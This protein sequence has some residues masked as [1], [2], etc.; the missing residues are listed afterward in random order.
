MLQL[1]L[2]K[3]ILFVT[4]VIFLGTI[5]IIVNV[6]ENWIDDKSLNSWWGCLHFTS[7]KYLLGK[8]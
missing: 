5:S 4:F 1:C 2:F 3:E 7:H 6:I 8:V